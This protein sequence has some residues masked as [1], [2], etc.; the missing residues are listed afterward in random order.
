MTA[1]YAL[2]S[3][4]NFKPLNSKNLSAIVPSPINTIAVIPSRTVRRSIRKQARSTINIGTQLAI[5][6]SR[7]AVA[8]PRSGSVR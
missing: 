8:K 6:T 3:Q 1:E 4:R 7:L 2:S 5:S